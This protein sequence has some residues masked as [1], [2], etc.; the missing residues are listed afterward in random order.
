MITSFRPSK[1]WFFTL[2][3]VGRTFVS[4]W[5]IRMEI[6][7]VGMK[8]KKTLNPNQ[9]PLLKKHINKFEEKDGV[10]TEA[11]TIDGDAGMI[12]YG[13]VSPN[14]TVKGVVFI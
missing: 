3:W 12:L 5:V 9:T 13:F 4:T 2:I 10:L 1:R 8:K 14:K 6:V 11:F 7:Y